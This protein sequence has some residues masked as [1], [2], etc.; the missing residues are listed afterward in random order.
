MLSAL[1]ESSLNLVF[2]PT[3]LGCGDRIH[4]PDNRLF[5]CGPCETKIDRIGGAICQR[6]GAPTESAQVQKCKRCPTFESFYMASRSATVYS[7]PIR[8]LIHEFKFKGS[9]RVRPLLCDLFVRGA[10]RHLESKDFD[11]IVPVPLHWWRQF[12]REFNQAEIL[13]ESLSESWGI[14]LVLNSVRRVRMTPPQSGL[15]GRWRERNIQGA[16][17]P[18]ALG[19]AGA[20]ALLVDDVMTTGRTLAA[21]SSALLKAG[22]MSVVGYTLSR[23]L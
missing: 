15:S 6:C 16:F 17:Q 1:V 22:A 8:E 5:L 19:L 18:G 13:G 7:T 20:R 14:P 21:C 4:S 11:L 3:C 10:D 23:R 12:R 2:P 9:R